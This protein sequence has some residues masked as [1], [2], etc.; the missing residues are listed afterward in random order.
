MNESGVVQVESVDIRAPEHLL[1]WLD[2]GR[3]TKCIN[4]GKHEIRRWRL[5]NDVIIQSIGMCYLGCREH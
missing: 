1:L 3:T 2:L 5:D 4:K